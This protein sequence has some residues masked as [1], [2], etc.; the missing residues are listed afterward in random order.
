MASG[1]FLSEIHFHPSIA[2]MYETE[3]VSDGDRVLTFID[4]YSRHSLELHSICIV[5]KNCGD[6]GEKS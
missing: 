3:S 4:S 2:R 5:R 6:G 1:L